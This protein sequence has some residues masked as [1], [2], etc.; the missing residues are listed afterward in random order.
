MHRQPLLWWK[1]GYPIRKKW[2]GV[3]FFRSD[4]LNIRSIKRQLSQALAVLRR[5]WSNCSEKE[6]WP[7]PFPL[8]FF[9]WDYVQLY[10][11][12]K[13]RQVFFC[14]VNPQICL[15]ACTMFSS[16]CSWALKQCLNG[17]KFYYDLR[18]SINQV[19][20]RSFKHLASRTLTQAEQAPYSF[21][22]SPEEWP[23]DEK[24]DTW[25]P[26]KIFSSISTACILGISVAF[27]KC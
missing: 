2:I 9:P 27:G 8:F 18:T 6:C 12:A 15:H 3:H 17:N 14:L 25:I 4:K 24:T 13:K 7:T 21:S 16:R 19:N 5:R 10:C 22:Q 20:T 1:H 26:R 11:I 23:V